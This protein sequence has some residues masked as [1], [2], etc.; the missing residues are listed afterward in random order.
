MR[1]TKYPRTLSQIEGVVG[2]CCISSHGV[3]V[4]QFD[5]KQEQPK[6]EVIAMRLYDNGNRGIPTD[7]DACYEVVASQ[8]E[9][10]LEETEEELRMILESDD[11]PTRLDESFN[12][13]Q[14][15]A[16]EELIMG[17]S[18]DPPLSEETVLQM[19]RTT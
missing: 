16:A 1:S 14:E 13:Q 4:I 9:I 12:Q 18:D 2:L 15:C 19:L 7:S 11:P 3:S 6:G 5:N 10:Y 8:E 17:D